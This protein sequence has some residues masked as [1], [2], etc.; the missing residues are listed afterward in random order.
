[1]IGL[2]KNDFQFMVKKQDDDKDIDF[3]NIN[4]KTKTIYI[5]DLNINEELVG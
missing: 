4:A 3:I 2:K 5:G 1:L